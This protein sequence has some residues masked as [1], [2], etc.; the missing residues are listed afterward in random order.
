LINLNSFAANLILNKTLLAMKLTVVIFFAGCLLGNVNGLAQKISLA[1]KKASLQKVFRSIEKQSGYLFWYEYPL[2][3]DTKKVSIKAKDI[4]LTEALDLC[5]KGLPLTYTIVKKTIVISPKTEA[6]SPPPSLIRRQADEL[7]SDSTPSQLEGVVVIGYGA[8]SKKNITGAISSV[9]V[10]AIEDQPVSSVDQAIAG[11]AAGVKVSQLTGTPGGGA[12]IRIR[13]TGS[14]SAGNEPLYVVDGFPIEK[15]YNRDLNPLAT[16]NPNDI[17]AIQ[18]LKDASSAAIYGSRGSNGVVLITTKRGKPGKPR[19]QFDTYYGLQKAAKT[20][21]MLNARE[22]AIYNTE[23]RNNAWMDLGGDPDDDNSLRP[24]RMKIPPMFADPSLLGEGT[25]WQEEVLTTAPVQNH[26]VSVFNGSEMTQYMLSLGYF[27]QRGIVINTGFERYSF[28]FNLDSKISDKIKIGLNIAPTYSRNDV[29]S[30]EDQVFSGGI[31]GSALAMPPTIPVYNEDG[32]YTTLLGASLYNFGLID[33]P[34]AI[35]N[36]LKGGT[37]AFRTLANL[38]AEWEI[39]E[40]LHL[41]SSIG[42]DYYEDRYDSYWPSTLGRSGIVPPVIPEA[43]ATTD[44][45]F[46]WLN[47]NTVTYSKNFNDRHFINAVAGVTSQRSLTESA[48]LTAINFPNDLVPTINAGQIIGGGTIRSEWSL[49]SYLARVN[50]AY[51]S[52]VLLTAT[53]RRD[54]SSRFGAGNKWGAFPSLS[55]GWNIARENFLQGVNAI[56]DLKLRVSYGYAGN[57]TIGNYNSI[58][59]LSSSPYVFGSGLGRVANGLE[60]I[61]LS[62]QQ[63]GWEVMRQTDIGLDLGL[64]NNRISLIVD[65]FDKTTS[66]LLLNVPVPGSTGF[67]TA[68]QN[69][70]KLSNKGWE[71]TVSSNNFSGRFKWR[72][73]FN[74]SFYKNKVLALGPEGEAIITNSRSFSPPT[75][76]TMVGLPIGSFFGYEAIGIYKDQADVDKNPIVQGAASSRPGDLKFRDTNGDG[77]ITPLDMK[78]IGNNNPDF[79]Y[80][81]TNSFSFRNFSLNILID[82]VEGVDVLNGS[83][84]NIGLVSNSY[85]RRDVLGRWQSPEN[86]GDGKT[87]RAN[88][89]P[90]GGNVSFVSSLLIEDA[91]F[92]RIRNINLRY[93]LPERIFR[94]VAVQNAGIFFSVQ[95][96]YTFTKYKGYNP[97]QNLNGANALTPGVDFNGYPLARTF[98][99][100]FSITFQ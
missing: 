43:N 70:G 23:A 24:D 16:I 45:S 19:V 42:G 8:L 57:N 21:D 64:W 74:I 50:Y 69:I 15:S 13:G 62:N 81:L 65:Y 34:V 37:S 88:I 99:A 61:N 44:R 80:G 56:S 90:T 27:N 98:T 49:F 59:L 54:G 2:L 35:A 18:I 5:L 66:D 39:V 63:L 41:R 28:R 12:I 51:D 52:R 58:G 82:G 30:V 75:H 31:L 72:T 86:P 46:V 25:D 29:L 67:A 60:P 93:R 4:S 77:V 6:A 53:I 89:A 92:L 73:D 48:Y 36:Q 26:Q 33:N 71:F 94:S 3:Q 20:I 1:E 22:Y 17:E 11:Q 32:T 79:S 95:N 55:A 38:F 100:G 7:S 14:I 97:E 91:S 40:G 87:P 83:R 68:L 76:I 85:S 47:E 78:I 84:R 96:A 10:R 9:N